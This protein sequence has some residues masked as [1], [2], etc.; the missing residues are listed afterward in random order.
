MP[1]SK[2]HKARTRA[3]IVEAARVLFNRHGFD[4]VTIDG[5]MGEAGLTRGGFYSHFSSK[6]ELFA[7]AMTSFLTGRG[8]QWRREA[9]VEPEAGEAEMARRMVDAYLS[10]RH[11]ED[12]DGQ[13][14]MIALSSDAARIGP[15][16]RASYEKLLT[17]MV[18]LFE[19]NIAGKSASPRSD[20]LAMAALCVGGMI[21]ART[22][23]ASPLVTEVRQA[24][25]AA[26]L[27]FCD[28]GA[29]AA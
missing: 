21:L 11:L 17:A 9:G 25:H 23:P 20:A 2:D 8:A 15:E 16:V 4:R 26:A 7:E 14:P 22:L 12:L 28:T 13:C 5:V 6:E 1:Y 3:R 27:S 19:T 10:S 24:A 18:W 29:K